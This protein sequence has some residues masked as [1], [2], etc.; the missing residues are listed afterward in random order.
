MDESNDK[1][2]VVMP[3]YN[4]E[5]IIVSTVNKWLKELRGLQIDF[6]MHVYNDGSSDLTLI[7]LQYLALKNSELVIHDKKNSGHGPTILRGYLDNS[8]VKWIFQTDSDNE[9]GEKSFRE[10]W[11]KKDKLDFLLGRRDG[12]K[13]PLGR[14]IVSSFSRKVAHFFYGSGVFDVNAPYRLMRTSAFKPYYKI[15]PEDTFAPNVI[16]AGIACLRKMRVFELTVPFTE[17]KT[18]QE[19]FGSSN[20]LKLFQ[21]ALRSFFQTVNFSWWIRRRDINNEFK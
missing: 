7:K 13:Q 17:R 1:L 2:A 4:E 21:V 11:D 14:K 6:K 15:I 20:R 18:G 16:I 5:E 12:R 8:D 3:V 9:M 19:T 10:L